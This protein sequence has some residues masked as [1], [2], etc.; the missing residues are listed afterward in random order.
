MYEQTLRQ[1]LLGHFAQKQREENEENQDRD[2]PQ[3]H[4]V[5]V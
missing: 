4:A 3:T 5:T 2:R 1:S